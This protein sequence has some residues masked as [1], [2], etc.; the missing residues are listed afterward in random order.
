MA[1]A[2]TRIISIALACVAPLG[3]VA[4]GGGDGGG[5]LQDQVADL[6]VGAITESLEGEGISFTIDE[7]CV[8]NLT[9]QLSDADAQ[10]ILDAGVDGEA[11]TSP[12]ADAVGEQLETCLSVDEGG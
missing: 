3:L 7:E 5:S 9:S 8:K 1:R 6:V 11:D 2:T 10:A 4:C 12:E